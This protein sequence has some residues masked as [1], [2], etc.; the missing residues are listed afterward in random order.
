MR[1]EFFYEFLLKIVVHV[2]K[3][4]MYIFQSLMVSKAIISFSRQATN[5]I[6]HYQNI[7]IYLHILYYDLKL[8]TIKIVYIL[9]CRQERQNFKVL[10]HII[11]L[12][13]C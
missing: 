7:Y 2:P 3:I 13:V 8:C 1:T 12:R 5:R 11:Y 4:T 10:N 6:L 9:F